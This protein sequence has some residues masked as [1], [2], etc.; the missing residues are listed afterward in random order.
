MGC[1]ASPSTRAASADATQ[2]RR[3]GR[4]RPGSSHTTRHCP[5]ATAGGRY[6]GFCSR[7]TRESGKRNRRFPASGPSPAAIVPRVY[8]AVVSALPTRSYGALRP[9]GTPR[10]HR[11]VHRPT[12]PA[13]R[14]SR[15]RGARQRSGP[16]GNRSSAGCVDQHAQREEACTAERTRASNQRTLNSVRFPVRIPAIRTAPSMSRKA[17]SNRTPPRSRRSPSPGPPEHH[18]ED[19]PEGREI[20][21]DHPAEM[22]QAACHP[23]A[24]AG[25]GLSKALLVHAHDGE[26]LVQ[27]PGRELVGR[28]AGRCRP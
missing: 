3:R 27:E 14:V 4:S 6:S 2:A 1:G 5:P 16:A 24:I 21:E 25:D 19:Q 23:P 10:R 18:E 11:G 28:A 20:N 13:P 26:V 17:P 22:E 8:P 9:S 15:R 12:A 7:I